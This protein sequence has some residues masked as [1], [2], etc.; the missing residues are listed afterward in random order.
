[1]KEFLVLR[2]GRLFRIAEK[3]E[4]ELGKERTIRKMCCK[5]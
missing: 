5:H 4:A 3:R 1:M 2:E